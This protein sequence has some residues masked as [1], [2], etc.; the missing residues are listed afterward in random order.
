MI[1]IDGVLADL[2]A[3]DSVLTDD[4]ID[5]AQRW[6][7]FFA[8]V[9]EAA[10]LAGGHDGL[11]YTI[12]YSTTRPSYALPAT[13]AW[14]T[15][16]DFPDSRAV[17]GRPASEYNQHTRQAWQIKLGHARAVINRH[18]AWLRGFVDDDPDA[19]RRLSVSGVR[20]HEADSLAQL[21]IASLRDRLDNP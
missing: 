9:P 10:V 19:V 12:V 6:R 16:Q 18:P 13:R 15:D 8:H 3:H 17:L 7:E 21:G 5:P 20:A 1:D 11:G 14:L 2:S 4:E